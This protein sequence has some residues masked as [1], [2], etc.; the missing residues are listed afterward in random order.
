MT[1]LE[2][3]ND[4]YILYPE[5]ELITISGQTIFKGSYNKL[6]HLVVR[7]AYIKV[8]KDTNTSKLIYDFYMYSSHPEYIVGTEIFKTLYTLMKGI[9]WSNPIIQVIFVSGK[10]DDNDDIRQSNCFR[11]CLSNWY[12]Y[13]KVVKALHT[14][15]FGSR[16][17]LALRKS[18]PDTWIESYGMWNPRNI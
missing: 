12:D 14:D 15:T 7:N 1:E 16:Y 11:D 3:I 17:K 10:F 6:S 13:N 18:I 9:N 4:E 8:N 2:W 5:L